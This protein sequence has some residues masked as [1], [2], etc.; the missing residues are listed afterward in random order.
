MYDK[1]LESEAD[2]SKLLNNINHDISDEIN[3]IEKQSLCH[4]VEDQ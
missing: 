4:P 1:I 3:F 2:L